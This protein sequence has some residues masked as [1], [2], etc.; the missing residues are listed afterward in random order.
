[1]GTFI[2]RWKENRKEQARIRR[3]NEILA[4]YF[5]MK[6][7]GPAPVPEESESEKYYRTKNDILRYN[8]SKTPTVIDVD[9]SKY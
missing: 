9:N 7:G 1:M 6:A 2:S 3:S 4:E 5:L 8:M